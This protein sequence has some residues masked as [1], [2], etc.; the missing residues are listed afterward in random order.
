MLKLNES[1]AVP[2]IVER[3]IKTLESQLQHY[4]LQNSVDLKNFNFSIIIKNKRGLVK[5]NNDI[6][7]FKVN[8]VL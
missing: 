6:Y 8:A 1:V 3:T 7:K 4:S 2:T 5:L